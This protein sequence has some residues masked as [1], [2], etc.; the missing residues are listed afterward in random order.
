MHTT[1]HGLDLHQTL[2]GL[3]HRNTGNNY[4]HVHKHFGLSQCFHKHFGRQP[5]FQGLSAHQ[6]R[7]QCIPYYVAGH[8][9]VSYGHRPYNHVNNRFQTNHM[10]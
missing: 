9:I 4:G 7:I 2:S 8:N 3:V 10:N 6:M 5:Y 1:Y